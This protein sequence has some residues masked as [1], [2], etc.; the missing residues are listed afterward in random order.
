MRTSSTIRRTA[1]GTRSSSCSSR[2]QVVRGREGGLFSEGISEEHGWGVARRRREAASLAE[3]SVSG[4]A[5]SERWRTAIAAIAASPKYGGLAITEQMGLLPIG[6]DPAS[7][8]WE[9]A[10]CNPAIRPS[11]TPR[12]DRQSRSR[13]ASCSC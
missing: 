9:F 6:P 12:P 1:G 2:T 7:G 4:S 11:A 8:L 5:A 10:V 13:R 3:R